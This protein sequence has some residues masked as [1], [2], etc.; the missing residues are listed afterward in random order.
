MINFASNL[1]KMID[2]GLGGPLDPPRTEVAVGHRVVYT[3]V[4]G[5]VVNFETNVIAPVKNLR[6]TMEPI[7]EGSGNPSPDNI[8][9]ITGRDAVTVC[10]SGADMGNPQSVT[11]QLGETVYGGLLEVTTGKLTVDRTMVDLGNLEWIIRNF[12]SQSG[13]ASYGLPGGKSISG[14]DGIME[15][16]VCSIYRI[17]TNGSLSVAS[18]DMMAAV[19]AYYASGCNIYVRDSRFTDTETFKTAMRGMQ[20]VYELATPQIITLTPAQLSTLKG[21]NNVWSDADSV[22]LEYPYY[23]ETEGY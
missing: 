18:A 2:A 13:F 4:S 6:V 20:L 16:A 3:E 22:T 12:G 1:N 7:Q 9:P 21:Q 23:E 8:R 17:G 5:D 19:G 14:A 10:R 11:V 15:K